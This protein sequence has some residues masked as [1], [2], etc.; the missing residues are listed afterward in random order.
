MHPLRAQRAADQSAVSAPSTRS[1]FTHLRLT[2]CPG[3]L[4]RD[5]PH[6][7]LAESDT[8]TATACD[9][10]SSSARRLALHRIPCRLLATH[11][12]VQLGTEG[13]KRGRCHGVRQSGSEASTDVIM[14]LITGEPMSENAATT[15]SS[16]VAAFE[17]A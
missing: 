4:L 15:R 2:L 13:S 9:G 8:V 14:P 10:S 16:R 6:P 12:L 17:E 7:V 3:S 11:R 5:M 1:T